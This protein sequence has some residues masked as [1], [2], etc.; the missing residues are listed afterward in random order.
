MARSGSGCANRVA[1][2]IISRTDCGTILIKSWD[3]FSCRRRVTAS[4]AASL[5]APATES[6]TQSA[7]LYRG[8]TR[9]MVCHLYVPR[10]CCSLVVAV[11]GFSGEPA[12]RSF[13]SSSQSGRETGCQILVIPYVSLGSGD[14][15][16]RVGGTGKL[17]I[18]T[19]ARRQG[20]ADFRIGWI[21][22]DELNK[23][24]CHLCVQ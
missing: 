6:W 4:S 20:P 18:S 21:V 22:P 5:V 14:S 10:C 8:T 3:L 7:R 2:I 1:T 24:L 17:Y 23:L 11:S 15:F 16:G 9:M 19:A 13:A 12:L